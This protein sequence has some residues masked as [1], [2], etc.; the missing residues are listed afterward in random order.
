MASGSK[1]TPLGLLAPA[2]RSSAGTLPC[3]APLGQVVPSSPPCPDPETRSGLGLDAVRPCSCPFREEG[4]RPKT[5]KRSLLALFYPL[6]HPGH[7]KHPRATAKVIAL[8][9]THGNPLPI[10]ASTVPCPEPP[11]PCCLQLI[12]ASASSSNAA[13]AALPNPRIRV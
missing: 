6:T 5:T 1:E 12:A 4:A 8:Y 10:V 7:A 9:H 13:E 3:H 11:H 2:K